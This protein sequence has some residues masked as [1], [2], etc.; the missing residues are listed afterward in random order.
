MRSTT[1]TLKPNIV[2]FRKFCF[3]EFLILLVETP[4]GVSTGRKSNLAYLDIT[5]GPK[6]Q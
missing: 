6:M 2:T 5:L 4:T 3:V 1:Y